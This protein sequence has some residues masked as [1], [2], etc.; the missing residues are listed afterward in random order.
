MFEENVIIDK[1]DESNS[2]RCICYTSL[3]GYK[4]GD[5]FNIK[6]ISSA[7][8]FIRIKEK[9]S[10]GA[11]IKHHEIR[12]KDYRKYDGVWSKNFVRDSYGY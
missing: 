1:I 2:Y 7:L 5:F 11:D 6:S 9:H 8:Q 4:R 10:K 3:D 12:F